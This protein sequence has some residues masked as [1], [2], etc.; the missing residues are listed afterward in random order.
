MGNRTLACASS[1]LI[2][3][4]AFLMAGAL[5][6][7]RADVL[8]AG[9]GQSE[10]S[11]DRFYS[12]STAT[13]GILAFG[14]GTI[15]SMHDTVEILPPGGIAG[16]QAQGPGSQITAENSNIIGLGRPGIRAVISLDG[17]LII[18]EGGKIQVA[19]DRSVGLFGDNGTVSAQGALAISMTGSDS[20]GVEARENGLVEINPNTV[21]TTSG[22]GGFGIF[23]S[24]G[25]TVTGNGIAITTS[26]F[27]GLAGFNADG[28]AALG[29]TINLENSGITTSG[30]NASGLHALG[31]NSQIFG[32][33][34]AIVTSGRIAA[35]AE[36]DNGGLIQLNGG[37]IATRGDGSFGL[38]ATN[39]GE[40]IGGAI[41]I[42][43]QGTNAAGVVA[44]TGGAITLNSG[45]AI[46]TQGDNASGLF[47]TDGGKITAE[48]IT[49]KTAGGNAYGALALAN[50]TVNLNPGTIIGTSGN[51]S[52][53]LL[54]VSGGNI[55][56]NGISVATSGGRGSLLNT[57]DGAAALAGPSGPATIAL[58]NSIIS[59]N[60]PGAN[61]LFVSGAGSSISLTNS[62][63]VSSKGNGAF[64]DN[65]ANLTLTG[66]SLTALL[67][68]IVATRGTA[69]AP[70]SIVVSGGN[71]V[72]VFGDA[73][74]VRN[75][76]TNIT[77]SNGAT[78]TGNSAL[79]RV[80][81]PPSET[82]VNLSASHASLIGDIFADPASQTTVRLTN[83]SVLTGKV[84]PLL[85]PGVDLTV[86]GSSQWV[87]TGSSNVK[88]L[89]VSPGT[90]AVFSTLFNG[91][92]NTLTLGSLFG[93][94][95]RFGLNINLR[96]DVGD[97][98][99]I[100]GTS[101]GS[102]R[103]TFFDRGTDLRPN[104]SL[105]VVKTRDG[106]AG[107]SG[108]TDRAVYKYYVV[109]GDGSRATPDPN[110]WYL[111]RADRIVRDQVER[112]AGAPAG[113]VNTPVGL[114]PVGSGISMWVTKT[115]C[116]P[117]NR[118]STQRAPG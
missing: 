6:S 97:L 68:G 44:E 36:A 75:G 57:A 80:L 39:A 62:N 70:N 17:G 25:G 106:V 13:P 102:H 10:V 40:I 22:N 23:A 52:F 58:Q 117:I 105:L 48:R 118:P 76:V 84:N 93:T 8:V 69:D 107:F 31:A 66:S 4:A 78:V 21:I 63:I 89:S 77:L 20:Y 86:D 38:I 32:K 59:A 72:T 85:S 49:V 7:V 3:P 28:A 56:G 47:A 65:G 37:S 91:A 18:L 34:L 111:V 1:A 71:L 14:G 87:M 50:G 16:L 12:T 99:D 112:P 41:N 55:V 67:H 53:G 45:V 11:N 60:G 5:G 115:L 74:Q 64:V 83:S 92:H 33:N 103:L 96:R 24:A 88:S 35:G 42:S 98:I 54:A 15:S 114:S 109:H 29:G 9:P 101:Q 82:V 46:I 113:S 43:T 94:G 90:S 26:G 2:L 110:D 108:M 104:E 61:G 95:G 79:L 81:D 116:K 30:D 51:G 27:L 100:T 19:G 73:F